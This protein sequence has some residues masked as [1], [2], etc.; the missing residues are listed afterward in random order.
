MNSHFRLITLK[1]QTD[2]GRAIEML[3]CLFSTQEICGQVRVMNVVG[4][5]KAVDLIYG[6]FQVHKT[7]DFQT[8]IKTP[9]F[10][11]RCSC[12]DKQGLVNRLALLRWSVCFL[13]IFQD[14]ESVRQLSR[15]SIPK[16][17]EQE[18]TGVR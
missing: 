16:E 3:C 6:L 18:R 8:Q 11:P 15:A 7:R 1:M 14:L 13:S 4:Q 2:A 12:L 5:T 10:I 9:C 17:T